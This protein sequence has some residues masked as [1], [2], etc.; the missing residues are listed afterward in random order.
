M[1]DDLA[2][3][4]DR[5][6]REF[7]ELARWLQEEAGTDRALDRIVRLAVRT[8]EGCAFAGITM[9]RGHELRTSAATGEVVASL[10]ALQSELQEGPCRESG[11]ENRAFY[12]A[13][14][15]HD[16]RWPRFG[17]RAAS[18]L[19]VL[20]VLALRL[21]QPPPFGSALNF[22]GQ[23]PDAFAGSSLVEA[24]IFAS[25]VDM[26]LRLAEAER[27]SMHLQRALDSNRQIG[28]AIGIL[29]AELK[30]PQDEA[31]AV[32][33]R[34][35]QHLHRKLRDVAAD[36]VFTGTLENRPPW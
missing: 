29:M 14:L 28:V 22:F 11:V 17:E 25:Q 35:S 19:G 2:G 15:R 24:T 34:A 10:D 16:R 1:T 36:V 5:M 33:T 21:V 23:E 3:D 31:F 20:S 8:V 18:Q 9:V 6:L 12:S 26:V 30:I 27:R 32:L 13:D 4:V 7:D